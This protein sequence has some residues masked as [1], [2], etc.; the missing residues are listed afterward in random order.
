MSAKDSTL[1]PRYC[2][3]V[4]L[5]RMRSSDLE[6]FQAYRLDPEVAALQGWS[7]TSD[8]QALRFLEEMAIAPLFIPGQWCQIG[9]ADPNSDHL[10]GDM[11]LCLSKDGTQLEFGISLNREKQGQGIASSALKLAI[12][13]VF[14][15][16]TATKIVAIT[17]ARNLSAQALLKRCGFAEV[18]RIESMY[19]DKPCVEIVYKL[20][21]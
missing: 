20:C 19:R 9:I 7:E 13:L 18:K 2:A 15:R 4:C 10:V 17:D 6:N 12:V 21:K 5:R 1:L 16:S 8:E 14:E 11:G 3:Q